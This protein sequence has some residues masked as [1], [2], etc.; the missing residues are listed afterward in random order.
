MNSQ[1]VLTHDHLEQVVADYMK[2]DA[3]T[4][5]VETLGVDRGNPVLNRV[6]WIQLATTGRCDVIPMG[7]PNGEFLRF[8]KPLTGT[9]QKRVASGKEPTEKDYS[10]SQILWTPVFTEPPEQLLPAE[11]FSALQPLFFSDKE[12]SGHNCFAGDTSVITSRGIKTLRDCASSAEPLEV[13]GGTCWEEG[14]A[15]WYGEEVLTEIVVAPSSRSRSSVSHTLRA[16]SHHRWEISRREPGSRGSCGMHRKRGWRPYL[17][18]T[19]DLKVGDWIRSAVPDTIVC[20]DSDGFRHGLIFAD[21]ALRSKLNCKDLP[22]VDSDAQYVTD[23][24]AGWVAFDGTNHKTST[25]TRICLTTRKDAVAWLLKNAALGGKIVTG[26]SSTTPPTG[27]KKK[28]GTPTVLYCVS[29]S[30]CPVPWV[31]RSIDRSSTVLED[32]FCV[33]VSST[34]RFTLGPGIYTAN[35]KFDVESIAKYY[36]GDIVPGPLFCTQVGSFLLDTRRTGKNKLDDCLLREFGFK[37]EKGVGKDISK[38][39]FMDVAEYGY[40]D[41]KMTWLLYIELK[42]QLGLKKMT[43]LMEWEGR[44]L[45]VVADMEL[46]GVPIDTESL[47]SFSSQLEKDLQSAS[48][49]VYRAA[50]FHFNINANKE[51]QRI[52]FGP[53]E[54][55]CQGLKP[56]G[57]TQG[58]MKKRKEGKPLTI[59]D[60]SVDE[61]ALSSFPNNKL[62][63]ALLEWSTLNKLYTG[64]AVGYQGGTIQKASGK[65]I[66]EVEKESILIKGR[67]HAQFNQI[68]A[69]TGRFTCVS[70][71]TI[72]STNRGAFR[73]DEYLPREGD[74]VLTHAVRWMPVLRKIYK[75]QDEMFSVHLENGSVLHCTKDHRLLT[76]NGWVRLADLS[77]GDEVASYGDIQSIREQLREQGSSS[78]CIHCGRQTLSGNSGFQTEH[79]SSE[80]TGLPEVRT[81]GGKIQSRK[82]FEVLSVQNRGAEPYAGEEWFPTPQLCGG[83]RGWQRISSDQDRQEICA[84]AQTCDGS[85]LGLGEVASLVG[86]ASHRREQ[87]EQRHRQSSD[88]YVFG[89]SEAASKIDSIT[90]L[91]TMGVWDIEV[92]GDHSYL[93]GGF[94][95]HNSVRPNLQQVPTPRSQRGRDIRNLFTPPPGFKMVVADYSQIEPRIMASHSGDPIMLENYRTGGDIY[96]TIGDKMGVERPEGKILVLSLAYGVGPAK[97]AEDISANREKPCLVKEADEMLSQFF[98][99]F[100]KI[101][102]YKNIVLQEARRARPMGVRTTL[103]K[104]VRY[105]PLLGSGDVYLRARAERQAFNTRIQGDAADIMKMAL[106]RTHDMLPKEAKMVLTIHDEIVTY[107]PEHMA[108]EVV[109]ITREAMEGVNALKIPLVADIKIVNRWGEAK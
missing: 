49:D 96:T 56:K 109:A 50:G 48:D 73:F 77:I 42:A 71:D 24:I 101:T 12:K 36:K 60:H 86:S 98:K 91:G 100:P 37:M 75:G 14:T 18:T 67:I 35:C 7:H 20:E 45:E 1:I 22:P 81:F 83:N 9:G 57:L 17:T 46:T 41:S 32:V 105:L 4:F 97:V 95:N 29:L 27:Y 69:E 76:L 70:G 21:G 108:D 54:E 102:Q 44:V 28:D 89:A 47:A 40:K 43:T 92:E 106:V 78:F 93:A 88:S 52:L 26:V 80:Y 107:C 59:Y 65:K 62:A 15:R 3:F 66:V 2:E 39:S 25:T 8:D 30:S 61:K 16:T 31:V 51:K 72:L 79:N 34:E 10:T 33:E 38:H 104:R 53:K 103:L 6:A 58:G 11:V 87:T 23:F 5:D 90:P 63:V 74:R 64:Y 19:E 99:L 55:S 13:W 82:S 84:D 85:S 68:G 94:I